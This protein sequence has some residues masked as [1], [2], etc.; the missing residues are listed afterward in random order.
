V[1]QFCSRVDD[2]AF[3]TMSMPLYQQLVAL[4]QQPP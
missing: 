4:M 2:N 3:A 1:L